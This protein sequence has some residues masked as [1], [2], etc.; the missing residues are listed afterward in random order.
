VLSH[1]LFF[2]RFFLLPRLLFCDDPSGSQSTLSEAIKLQCCFVLEG[3]WAELWKQ[4]KEADAVKRVTSDA[5]A[6]ACDI[7]SILVSQN[8]LSK[9]LKKATKY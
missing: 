3:R 5:E 1:K 8:C 6:D 4:A 2:L 9:V 7:I